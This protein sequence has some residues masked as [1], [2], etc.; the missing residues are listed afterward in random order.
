[1][2]LYQELS[3]EELILQVLPVCH[4]SQSLRSAAQEE[5]MMYW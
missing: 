3:L 5:G 2:F 1:M 4:G